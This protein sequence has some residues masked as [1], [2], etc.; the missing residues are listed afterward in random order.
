MTNQWT[1]FDRAFV[2]ETHGEV[3]MH[4]KLYKGEHSELFTRAKDLVEKGEI[5]DQ[6]LFGRERAK[7]Q[8]TPYIIANLCKLIVEVP[9]T[10][11]SRSIGTVTTSLKATPAEPDELEGP[12]VDEAAAT[13]SDAIV[14]KTNESTD[15]LI[16]GPE[17]GMAFNTEILNKQQE[18]IKQIVDNSKLDAKH[19][20]NIIMLQVDG[21]LVGVPR[22]DDRGLRIEFKQRDV[23]YPHE[24]GMGC[25]VSVEFEKDSKDYLHVYR[26]RSEKGNLETEH[27]LYELNRADRFTNPVEEEQAKLILNLKQL[28]QTFVGR[29]QTLVDYMA[30]DETFLNPL[31]VSALEGQ[32]GLQDEINWTLTRNGLT[33]ERNGRPRMSVTTGIMD[34]LKEDAEEKYGDA[35]KIDHR[36]LELTEMDENGEAIKIHQIDVSKIGDVAWVKDL[37]KIM[38]MST[39]TS[40]RAV[41]YYMDGGSSAQSGI[42]KYYDLLT[43]LIKAERIQLNYLTFLKRLVKSALWLQ[44]QRDKAVMIEEPEI[45]LNSMLPISR[46]ELLDENNSAFEAGTQSLETTVRRN[47]P[48]ASDEWIEE[49][50]IRIEEESGGGSDDSQTLLT[51]AA[52]AAQYLQQRQAERDAAA[53]PATDDDVPPAE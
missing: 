16:D 9:A 10:F 37:M 39:Q 2:I 21:G 12:A 34:A 49:E 38:L 22:M 31:G 14:Q 53:P 33:F 17:E 51:G 43:S 18:L 1:K 26:E 32:A 8:K 42:A 30:N 4:R 20:G 7:N 45:Q 52:T 27:F 35:N 46:Q 11:V 5:T 19:Y 28:K 41:D 44:H 48:T 6:I 13:V 36:N 29:S 23:Y 47:N 40:E 3:Y 15:D 24:D 25:D 50:L